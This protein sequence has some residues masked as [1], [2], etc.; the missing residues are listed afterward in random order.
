M[1]S[2]ASATAET[3]RL[4]VLKRY[5]LNDR[6]RDPSLDRITRLAAMVC[7]TPYAAITMVED[8]SQ[9]LKSRYCDSDDKPFPQAR[10]CRHVV[11]IRSFLELRDTRIDSDISP[12]ISHS[13]EFP[14]IRFYAG[15]PLITPE[16]EAL[17]VLCVFDVQ[18]GR[19]S[20]IQ[21]E[22][23][24]LLAEQVVT[25]LSQRC[26]LRTHKMMEK[27]G[28]GIWEMDAATRV[29][30]WN[31]VIHDLYDLG[32]EYSRNLS[33]HLES[34]PPQDRERLLSA[35]EQAVEFHHPFNDTYQM[36][37]AKGVQRWVRITGFPIVA[38]GRVEQLIGTLHDVTPR[39]KIESQLLQQQALERAIMRAQACFIDE[40]DNTIAFDT[41]LNDILALTHSEY[42]FIGEIHRHPDQTPY[43]QTQALS[44]ITW[45][46]ASR[47]FYA[48]SMDGMVFSNLDTLFGHVMVH[49]QTVISN[50][51]ADDPRSQGL[52]AGHPPLKAFLGVPIHVDNELVAM[53]GLTNRPGGYDERLVSFLA[54]LL[55]S[56]GQ[57]VNSLRVHRRHCLDQQA[58][59]R[60]SM[61]ARKTSNG[62]LITDA[63]GAIE[64]INEG[65]TRLSGYEL[66]D[67][68]GQQ[69][70]DLLLGPQTDKATTA[71]IID[72]LQRQE[73]FEE[74]L[75]HYRKDG[76]TYWAHVSCNPLSPSDHP[77]GGFIALQSDISAAKAHADALYKVANL[78]ELTGLPNLRLIHS[79]LRHLAQ[80]AD[81]RQIGL[82]VHVLDLDDFKRVNELLGHES[83]DTVLR[84]MAERLTRAVDDN[85]LVGRLGGDEF[86]VILTEEEDAETPTSE[87]LLA[88]IAPPFELSGQRLK[89]TTSLGVTRY[90]QDSA[91]P[92]T[93]IRHAHQAL[94]QAKRQG[95]GSVAIYDAAEELLIREQRQERL[96]IA[97]ALQRDEF[98]LFYQPQVDLK[99]R[100]VIGVEALIRWQHP[101]RGLLPPA[102]FLPL[103]AG[104]EL[105]ITLGE[106]V[107]NAALK[108]LMRWKSS[109]IDVPVSINISPQH[110]LHPGFITQF[111][112][113]LESFP[114]LPPGLLA[115]EILESATLDDT[116]AALAVLEECRR[117][118]VDVAL[119]DFGTGYS[120]LAY[121]R[122]LPVQ[123]IKVDRDFVRDMLV[124][125]DDK[126][127][128]ESVVFLAR[129]FS[130][131]VL[132]EGVETMAHAEALV[133]LGCFLAQGYGIARPMPAADFPVWLEEWQA[134]Q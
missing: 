18:P 57:L 95:A 20:A 119:D 92:D 103:V 126:A 47:E 64:W 116:Q 55:G 42:G 2:P 15:M 76:S 5:T 118:R 53:L 21:R 85:G 83:A 10:F 34:Y 99:T 12:A 124:N 129:K 8:D 39:K 46:Q 25:L 133:D 91:D 78:D 94:Y 49:E 50:H 3:Q 112:S 80:Q 117:L 26:L 122:H 54:P 35:L 63:N 72:A 93:L 22:L 24:E 29:T 33:K 82:R 68:Q 84:L 52:P 127:I 48:Q 28:I 108:Q 101:Q 9:W 13:S 105:E 130:R 59:A 1:Q 31:S 98:Q 134:A 115:L 51:P 66:D 30:C 88:A 128:V 73:S 125:E 56:I 45:D 110:L 123:L 111:Q 17:G 44:D 77:G 41:L 14:H 37:S 120:S 102:A 104:C 16:G 132:A 69:P 61:V 96:E 121:F 131:A 100:R 38:N 65:F 27:A 81:T 71:R 6:S 113:L 107:I 74:E 36:T 4:L 62:V 90:P 67:A 89:L 109:G 70:V 7:H 75:L 11:G 97:D 32:P 79:Q 58:I 114:G 106:W 19:L 40:R 87:T 86:V 23:I 43:M 60:L